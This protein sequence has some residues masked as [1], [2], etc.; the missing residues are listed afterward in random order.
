[1]SLWRVSL[2]SVPL[3]EGGDLSLFTVEH[4]MM[5][6]YIHKIYADFTNRS[7]MSI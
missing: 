6:V 7:V 1:M 5:H 4:T 3:C 2:F